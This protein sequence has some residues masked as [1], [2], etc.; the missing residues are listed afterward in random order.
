MEIIANAPHD[1]L[2]HPSAHP[3]PVAR[4]W[5][6]LTEERSDL[7][8]LV[9]YTLFTGLLSLAVPLTAQALVNTIAA[10]LFVQ[11]LVVLTLLV[12]CG[13]LFAGV[14]RLMQL[15]LVERLQERVFARIALLLADRLTRVRNAALE[16]EY[17]P[18]LVNRFFDTLT[19][20]KTLAKLLLDGLAAGLQ[21]L[22]GLVL[23]A[24]YSPYLLGFD[25]FLLAFVVF[26]LFGLGYNG[27]RTSIQESAQKYRVAEWLEELARCQVSFKMSGT[28]SYLLER[29]DNLIVNYLLARRSH[30]RVEFRQAFGSYLFQA[31]ASAGVLG[32]GGFLV[33]NRQLTLG[34]LVASELIVVSVLGAIEK[35]IRQA[36]P[37]YDLLTGLDKVGHVTDLAV[38]RAGGRPLPAGAGG[39]SVRCRSVRFGY[40]HGREVLSGLNLALQPGERVSLVGVS[41]AGKSTLA[42][43]LCGLEEPAQGTVEI[44]GLDVR[45]VELGSLRDVV[46]LVGDQNEIFEGTLEENVVLGRADVSH[47]AVRYALECAQLTEEI[48][49]M[50]QGLKTPLVSAGRNLSRGQIQRLLLARAIVDRPRLLILDEAFTGI[51]EQTKLKLLDI[52]YA[53]EQSWTILNISHD[54]EVVQRSATVHVLQAG[55]IVESGAPEELVL[56]P[57]SAFAALFPEL[58]RQI[59]GRQAVTAG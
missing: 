16:G 25:L 24:F 56:R 30:F 28:A 4:L 48:A 9:V 6:L 18:E 15:S 1:A 29:A 50:A 12:L 35:L 53:P 13:L 27:L 33:I 11:P 58:T 34:Q 20:Q 47:E 49:R 7:A 51:D 54:A 57:Q 26:T 46:A 14:L 22:G 2:E 8:A 21:A 55:E 38:E 10:G 45:D 3:T 52:I 39:A 40:Q 37:V 41:G 44:N 17:G 32:I 42:A 59:R 23:L 19:I 5:R 36:E 31:F 43:L